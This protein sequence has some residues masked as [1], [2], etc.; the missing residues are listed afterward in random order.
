MPIRTGGY[1]RASTLVQALFQKF[2]SYF[3]IRSAW[4]DLQK[5]FKIFAPQIQAYKYRQDRIPLVVQPI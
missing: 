3:K 2:V 1:K 4:S 5:N